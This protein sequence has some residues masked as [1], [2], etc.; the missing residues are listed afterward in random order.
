MAGSRSAHRSTRRVATRRASK[1]TPVH[2][3]SRLFSNAT[4]LDVL[5]QLLLNPGRDYYQ[6][7]LVTRTGRALLQVQRALQRIE[8]AGLA[9]KTRRGNRAYYRAQRDHPVFEDL[10]RVLLKTVALGDVLRDGL[11]SAGDSIRLAFIFGSFASG[12]ESPTSDVDLLVVGDLDS[13]EAAVLLGP[14]GREL[15]REFNPVVYSVDEFRRRATSHNH[16]VRQV[17]KSSRIWLI[18]NEEALRRLVG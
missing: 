1:R 15:G 17:L 6:A 14:L 13:K 4:V 2:P 8:E 10:K 16:F 12:K 5:S 7:E 9:N 11:A 3:L 18:G